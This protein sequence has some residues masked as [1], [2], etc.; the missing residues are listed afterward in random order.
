MKNICA[1]IILFLGFSAAT[2][3]QNL[4]P[5]PSFEEVRG[6]PIASNPVNNFEFERKSGFKAF[7]R[8]L[9]YWYAATATTPDL[10]IWT[11]H[12]LERCG[13]KYPDCDRARTGE[14]AAGIVTFM[15]NAESE[16]YR[17]YLG[18][19]LRQPLVPGRKT[20]VAFWI[21]KERQARLVSNNI[22]C[23]FSE[24]KVFANIKSPIRVEPQLNIQEVVSADTVGW[25]GKIDSFVPE[26]AYQFLTIGNFF[27]NEG[28][29]VDT[30]KHWSGSVFPVSSAYYL[31]DDLRV[32]QAGMVDLS[33]EGKSLEADSVVLLHNVEFALN[34]A[35]L[36]PASHRQLNELV[37]FLL[38]N[39]SVSIALQGHTDDTGSPAENL[40]LSMA[41]AKAV[42]DHLVDQGIDARRLSYQGFGAQQPIATN[43]TEAG[44]AKNRRVVF[45]VLR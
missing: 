28:T 11:D 42:Y 7:E 27:D 20:Y 30:A 35:V 38:K 34:S 15:Q 33:F 12:Y 26:K 9:N 14:N 6:L 40:S 41:R 45:R 18:V 25:V 2:L 3:G 22:G 39:K 24:R 29:K 1:L 32:W 5:N 43:T 19:K 4:V 37:S 16:V 36:Q 10:R 17:E 21:T 44:R 23:Y 31:L 13:S 8:H